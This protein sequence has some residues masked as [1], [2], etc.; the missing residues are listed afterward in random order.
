MKKLLVLAAFLPGLAY[1]GDEPFDCNH[2]LSLI[3]I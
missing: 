3:H 1:A 2:N